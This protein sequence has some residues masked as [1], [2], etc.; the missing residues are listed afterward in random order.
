MQNVNAQET[1]MPMTLPEVAEAVGGTLAPHGVAIDDRAAVA[2]SAVS[3]SRQARGGSVFVAITGERVDGHDF[4]PD[5]A[6][7][8]AACALVDHEVDAPLPQIVVSDTVAALGL[9]ARHNIERRRAEADP[10]AIVGITGSV[11]KTTTKDLLHALLSELGGT[12]APVGSFN[13]EVGLPLTALKVNASTRFFVAEMGAN[14]VGEIARL[15]TIAP[16]DVAVVLKVGVAHL[17]EFGSVER[18]AQAKSE[19]VRG[20]L[21]GGVSVLNAD[22]PHVAAME[23]IAPGDVLWFGRE[24]GSAREG[25]LK[26]DGVR[27]TGD[28]CAAFTMGDGRESVDVTLGIRGAHNVMNALAAASVACH[29]GMGLDRIARVL[30]AQRTISDHRMAVSRVER[31]G[32]AFTLIDDSFNANPDSMRAGLDALAAWHGEG[33]R[34]YRIGVLGAMLELG[35]DERRLHHDIGAYAVGLG[36]DAVVAVGGRDPHLDALANALAQGARESAAQGDARV[37]ID[38]V[39]DADQADSR[40]RSLVA[41]RPGC[42]VLLKGSHASGLSALASR[43]SRPDAE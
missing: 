24:D 16:P 15:T 4:L 9:L 21:P 33:E 38:W 32:E 14:H 20:L 37:S 43:W 6:A 11:G 31:G 5:V 28:G 3:D 22:D 1:M 2:T 29:F 26:A 10:F 27:L 17:G 35:G 12:V 25:E 8:G 19:I 13:N 41:G 42:V 39:H 34:L 18:I 30:H 36:L 40:V 7:Q 23:A